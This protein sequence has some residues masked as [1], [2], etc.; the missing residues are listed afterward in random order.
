MPGFNSI[1]FVYPDDGRGARFDRMFPPLGLEYVAAGVR[2]CFEHRSL[3]DFRFDEN[4]EEQIP[5]NCDIAALSLL[6]DAPIHR[7]LNVSRRL[8]EM[9]PG[10]RIVAGGRVAE[11]NKKA[12]VTATPEERVDVVFSGPD[13]G[14]F[15][16]YVESGQAIKV[17]GVSY[18]DDGEYRETAAVFQGP[19]PDRPLPD[20][21]M[22]KHTYG[23]IRRDGFDAGVASDA[24]QSSR[25]CPYHCSFCTFNR[26]SEGRHLAFTGRS[27]ESVADELEQIEAPYVMFTDDNVCHDIKRME[28]LCD[29]LIERKIDKVYGL[30]TRVNIGLRPTLVEKMAR[31]GFRHITFGLESMH[32]H[33]LKFLNKDLKRRTIE[34]A[35]SRIHHMDMLFIGNFIIGNVGE[36]REQMLQIPKFAHAIGLDSVQINHLRCRGPEP[37]TETVKATP[38]YYIDPKTR[39]VYSDE[40]SLDDMADISRQIKREFWTKK[41]ILRSAWKTKKLMTPISF[42]SVAWHWLLW[43]VMGRPDPWGNR[44]NRQ[45]RGN[46]RL[47]P[48][49]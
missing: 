19:I 32:D 10:I 7:M 37:L 9:R 42:S 1:A 26:D 15:R 44:K 14:R 2:D 11:V 6:W 13:D 22:R 12:L 18:L 47:L 20:R 25:G 46:S 24:I 5:E 29:L 23:M 38:G 21:T 35:F 31:A 28:R 49:Y 27:A 45:T 4:W 43:E 33:V 39:K 8:K 34:R 17:P 16:I 48:S 3:I 36:T 40:N 41:Q 30:E